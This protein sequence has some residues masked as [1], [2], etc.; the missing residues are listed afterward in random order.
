LNVKL[1]NVFVYEKTFY[2]SVP[3]THEVH[4]FLVISLTWI[5]CGWPDAPDW[6]DSPGTDKN[7]PD[8]S[9]QGQ[10]NVPKRIFSWIQ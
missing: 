1:D 8:T 3:K 4:Y 6:W 5:W 9:I 7:V 2:S 10:C